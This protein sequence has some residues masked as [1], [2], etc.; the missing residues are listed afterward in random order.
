MPF[1]NVKGF[2]KP[3]DSLFITFNGGID[4]GVLLLWQL[5][6]TWIKLAGFYAEIQDFVA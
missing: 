5:E 3:P 1:I 6:S 2:R 4:Q